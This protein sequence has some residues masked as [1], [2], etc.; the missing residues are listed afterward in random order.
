MCPAR[1]QEYFQFIEFSVETQQTYDGDVAR[2]RNAVEQVDDDGTATEPDEETEKQQTWR[3]RG[4]IWTGFYYFAV[5]NLPVP[6]EHWRA[7][8]LRK[9]NTLEF[10]LATREATIR[11]I[12]AVFNYCKETRCL[13]IR[14]PSQTLIEISINGEEVLDFHTFVEGREAIVQFGKL[15]YRLEYTDYAYDPIYYDNHD[16][17]IHDTLKWANRE[18]DDLT[19]TPSANSTKIGR[20]ASAS[21]SHAVNNRSQAVALK[22]RIRKCRATAEALS[23]V[24]QTLTTLTAL[25]KAHDEP[26]ILRLHQVIYQFGHPKYR[27]GVTEDVHLVLEPFMRLT[28]ADII[29]L[30]KEKSLEQQTADWVLREAITGLKFLHDNNWMHGDIKPGN[31]GVQLPRTGPLSLDE[32]QKESRVVLLDLDG[33]SNLATL[34]EQRLP[35]S[36]MMSG[37]WESLDISCDTDRTRG[38][39][40][41][42]L[43]A[44]TDLII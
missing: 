35:P 27:Q 1:L 19:H 13:Q 21:V 41:R 23:I 18:L 16:K 34:P 8:K 22:T 14:K 44:R 17:F 43:G 5:R 37:L 38:N 29:T 26:R 42:T 9:S 10:P 36:T 20:G 33:A 30:V 7:G 24:I 11:S 4:T 15:K 31:I 25:A 3:E 32:L 39:S 2:L 40:P 6:R 28:V 12:H